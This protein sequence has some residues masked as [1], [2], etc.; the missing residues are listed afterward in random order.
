VCKNI[1]YLKKQ[2]PLGRF[3]FICHDFSAL[4]I[5]VISFL[6]EIYDWFEKN[7]R[8]L[9]WRMTFD[10]YL[11][12]VSEVVLQ[13]TRVNQGL[14]YFNRFVSLFPDVASLA[15]APEDHLLK[16]WEGLGYY[17]RARNL[18][19]AART[20]MELHG[21]VFPDRYEAIRS[22]K[23]IGDYTAAAVA[24]IAFG[25][26]YAVVDGN[27]SRFLSRYLGIEAPVDSLPG[28]KLMIRAAD[29]L[30]DISRP[31]FHN[32]AMMEFGALLCKPARP[33][34]RNCPVQDGCYA[35]RKNITEKLPVKSKKVNRRTRYFYYCIPENEQYVILEKRTGKDIWKNLYQFP[36]FESEHQLEEKEMLS[37]PL[38]AEL[39][40]KYSGATIGISRE[41]VH[42]LTH[43]QIRARFIRVTLNRREITEIG[44]IQAAKADITEYPF[45]VLIRNFI[46][47]KLLP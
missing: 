4:S 47:E 17:S 28:K 10:P 34:C 12:W 46:C 26:P 14:P 45:P 33:D 31:G 27:V 1:N 15:S 44:G 18:Q 25:Q 37:I 35:F 11:I 41:Y 19:A 5:N 21:G 8:E 16:A 39:T 42:E 38:L 9:P 13:Q 20:I 22:L 3:I 40:G 23:G 24:S 36:L 2:K 7:R 32:Q 43:Q 30:L 29:E 6:P